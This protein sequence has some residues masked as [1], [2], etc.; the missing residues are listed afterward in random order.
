MKNFIT[1]CS[2][3]FLF[4]LFLVQPAGA[5]KVITEQ[6]LQ[7]NIVVKSQ[8]IRTADNFIILYDA[9]GSMK[10]EYI[11]GVKKIDAEREILK[12]QS[13]TLPELGYQ[14][15]LYLFTPFKSYYDM[16]VYMQAVNSLPDTESA[17]NYADQPTPLPEGIQALDPILAKLSGNTVVF[18]FS[19]GTYT[20]DKVK[21]LYPV[22]VAKDLVAKHNV[23]FYLISS[24]TT[25]TAKK[26]LDDIAALNE[27][28]R[29]VSF[30]ALYKNPV[31]GA[32]PLFV[33]DSTI[34]IETVTDKKIVG[35]EVMDV[36][37]AFDQFDVVPSDY[38]N[39][40]NVAKFLQDNPKSFVVLAGFTDNVGNSEYNLKLSR[41]RVQN[42]KNAILEQSR[43]D[44]DRVVIQWYGS[45]NFVASNDTEEGRQKNRRVEIAIGLLE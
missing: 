9:S 14:A 42:T 27:C 18:I 24:A 3:L 23:C 21:R 22:E 34:D 44:A 16:K 12:Q 40:K 30:D 32:G 36:H 29:V 10:D 26:L 11:P 33:V 39:L 17:G 8:L 35:V 6:D 45:T 2:A 38:S 25:P 37:F 41:V 4:F 28:S 13:A 19:D 5:F 7:E 15:G 31:W 43:I 20:F 1:T